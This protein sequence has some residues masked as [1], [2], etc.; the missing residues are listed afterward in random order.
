MEQEQMTN[1]AYMV[2]LAK[3]RDMLKQK[4]NELIKKYYKEALISPN[5]LAKLKILSQGKMAGFSADMDLKTAYEDYLYLKNFVRYPNF[6][7]RGY[8]E[9]IYIYNKKIMTYLNWLLKINKDKGLKFKFKVC[10][11]EVDFTKK[12]IHGTSLNYLVNITKPNYIE[13]RLCREHV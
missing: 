9:P 4:E 5:D 12:Y 1:H 8:S 13:A 6:K 3:Y 7:R 11:N 2:E 10:W